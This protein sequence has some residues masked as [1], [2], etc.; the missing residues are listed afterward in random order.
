[1]VSLGLTTGACLTRHG[2]HGS[3]GGGGAGV[4]R[5]MRGTGALGSEPQLYALDDVVV[6]TYRA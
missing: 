4:H 2:G 6:L 3:G 1:M 5:I